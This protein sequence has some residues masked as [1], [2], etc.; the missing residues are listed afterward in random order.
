MPKTTHESYYAAFDAAL[1]ELEQIS[2]E[3]V[4]MKL[5]KD[6]VEGDLQ[7]LKPLVGSAELASQAAQPTVMSS[8]PV[9]PVAEPE[10][11]YQAPAPPARL[12]VNRPASVTTDS[13]QQRIDS[14]LGL[15]IA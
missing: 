6:R 10:P 3:F 11:V 14:I 2:N 5:R 1:A 9:S 7:A 8:Q 13:I 12:E 4:Q 15:A